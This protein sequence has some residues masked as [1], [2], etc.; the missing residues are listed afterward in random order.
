MSAPLVV[1]SAGSMTG[2]L[3]AMLRRYTAETGNRV[4]LHTGPAGLLLGK[5]EDGDRVDLF[6]SANMKHPQ[7]L[8]AEGKSTATV[9]FARNRICVSAL[10]AVGL[11]S[12][13]L[14][15]KLLDLGTAIGTSTPKADPGGDYAWELF[16]KAGTVRPGATAILKAKAQQLVGGRIESAKPRGPSTAKE[17]MVEH[18]IN[19]SIGY[20]SSH[21]MTPDMSVDRVELPPDLAIRVNYGMTVLTTAR[22]GARR[23]AADR[24]ALYLMSPVVQA[25]MVPYGFIP[26][27]ANSSAP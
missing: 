15:D 27:A 9:V 18:H 26:V 2:A 19:V 11:T 21:E 6:I 13:N 7:K 24:L 10:P 16:D 5:I 20:C 3:G 23:E 14:L 4:D 25:M 8:T 1:Y 12:A 17:F 22:D